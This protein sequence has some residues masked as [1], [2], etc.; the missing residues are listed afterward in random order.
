MSDAFQIHGGSNNVFSGNIFD[1][2][3]GN[4]SF[5]LLQKD[6]ADVGPVGAF[7]Q[8]QNNVVTGNIFTTES[9]APRNPGFSDL[10]DG[11]GSATVSGNDYWAFSGIG[12]NIGGSGSRGDAAP[13]S[14]A[15]A[16]QAAG[17]LGDYLTWSGGGINFQRIDTSQI[18]L[19][20]NGAHAF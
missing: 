14:T 2:G 10:T 7:G 9:F 6:E 5:G 12:L 8:L 20:P 4:T 18:G 19:A 13:S 17:S 1:L 3:T 16:T 15:P 11:I